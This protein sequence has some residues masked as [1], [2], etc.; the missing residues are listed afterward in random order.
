MMAYTTQRFQ[1]QPAAK[2][3]KIDSPTSTGDDKW[4]E[5][6]AKKDAF[7]FNLKTKFSNQEPN[8]ERRSSN[9]KNQKVTFCKKFSFSY[10]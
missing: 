4:E 1:E 6:K 3:E 10:S 7:L 9:G 8:E 5:F 2:F